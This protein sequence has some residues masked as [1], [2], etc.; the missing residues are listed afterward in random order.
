MLNT[1]RKYKIIHLPVQKRVQ[2][3]KKWLIKKKKEFRW[4]H[5][6]FIT[7]VDIVHSC[8]MFQQTLGFPVTVKL[9]PIQLDRVGNSQPDYVLNNVCECETKRKESQS[10]WMEY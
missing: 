1:G 3:T 5:D 2:Q 9:D 6:D 4:K 10:L 8:S 7:W